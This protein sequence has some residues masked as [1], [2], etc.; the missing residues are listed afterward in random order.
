MAEFRDAVDKLAE[1]LA[2]LRTLEEQRMAERDRLIA[3]RNKAKSDL[4]T[5]VAEEEV[6]DAN[7]LEEDRLHEEQIKAFDARRAEYEAQIEE[8]RRNQA[9]PADVDRLNQ[10]VAE[11]ADFL[12]SRQTPV[13][14]GETEN[15]TGPSNP[16]SPTE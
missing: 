16:E 14:Q 9:D 11:F 12:A 8:L 5:F 10:V 6:E 1:G 3:E 4:D 13:D 7:E 15:P 2:A